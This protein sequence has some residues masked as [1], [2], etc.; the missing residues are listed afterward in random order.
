MH[1]EILDSFEAFYQ[2]LQKKLSSSE[3]LK[4]LVLFQYRENTKLNK[5]IGLFEPQNCYS[6]AKSSAEIFERVTNASEV[7]ILGNKL[8]KEQVVRRL[9]EQEKKISIEFFDESVLRFSR[10]ESLTQLDYALKSQ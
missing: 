3:T 7:I 1:E 4:S 2:I 8:L 9:F 6:M 10:I 5:I